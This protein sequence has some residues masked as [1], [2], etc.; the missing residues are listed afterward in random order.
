LPSSLLD[1]DPSGHDTAVGTGRQA[2]A[3]SPEGRENQSLHRGKGK[4]GAIEEARRTLKAGTRTILEVMT[5][6]HRSLHH[7]EDGTETERSR[8]SF[9]IIF[10]IF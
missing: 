4:A 2:E 3:P 6:L 10:I 7:I 5:D 1:Q 9:F 8:F